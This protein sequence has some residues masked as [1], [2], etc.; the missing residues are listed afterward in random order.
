MFT[1]ECR[2][3]ASLILR[4]ITKKKKNIYR[5]LKDKKIKTLHQFDPLL[6]K[7]FVVPHLP[8]KVELPPKAAMC[9][10]VLQLVFRQ[11]YSWQ[12]VLAL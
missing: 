12:L 7:V 1:G 4:I 11:L 10:T 9:Y 6:F 5:P 3:K 8:V 2:L